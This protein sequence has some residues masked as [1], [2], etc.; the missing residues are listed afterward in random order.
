MKSQPVI[1]IFGGD[2][3]EEIFVGRDAER[4]RTALPLDI[5]TAVRFDFGKIGHAPGV[6]DDMT[7]ADDS[8]KAATGGDQNH[9]CEESYR[10]LIH[11]STS[12]R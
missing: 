1:D 8:A 9:G 4:R 5:K 7:I 2:I 3:R 10:S 12:Y 6:G 11:N